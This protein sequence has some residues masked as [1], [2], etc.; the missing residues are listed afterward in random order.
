M[1]M[2]TI[3]FYEKPGCISNARQKKILANA[4]HLLVVY[5]LS[6]QAW[7]QQQ[8]K[9]RSFFGHQSVANWFNPNAPQ[10]KHGELNPALLTESQAI[11]LM[12]ATPLLIRRPLIE[13]DGQRW[14]GFHQEQLENWLGQSLS[15]EGYDLEACLH[16]DYCRVKSN[17]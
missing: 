1:V 9:L 8:A 13:I 10:I 3:H 16:P 14:A 5:D 11:A 15:H 12:V 2:K 7:G 17:G 6:S 4:G